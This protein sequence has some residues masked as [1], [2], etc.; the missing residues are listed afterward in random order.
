MR[1]P[2]RFANPAVKR[3]I[4]VGVVCA[5]G[6]IAGFGALWR[7]VDDGAGNATYFLDVVGWLSVVAGALLE[8][9][10]S[11]LFFQAFPTASRRRAVAFILFGVPAALGG[12]IVASMLADEDTPAL[13]SAAAMTALVAG[14]G[15]G[16]AGLFSLGATYG[17]D[18]AARRIETLGE[19]EW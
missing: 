19:E 13:L 18:Y 14:V 16:L 12:C 7:A 2:G 4:A 15:F 11:V 10:M 8:A 17:G 3:R 1:R 6:M 5:G 9:R